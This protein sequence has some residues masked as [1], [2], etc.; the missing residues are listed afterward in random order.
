MARWRR[1]CVDVTDDGAVIG[2]SVEY[3]SDVRAERMAV[4]VLAPSELRGDNRGDVIDRLALLDWPQPELPLNWRIVD[5][6]KS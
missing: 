6:G 3:Y 4:A 1:L 5:G 2:A